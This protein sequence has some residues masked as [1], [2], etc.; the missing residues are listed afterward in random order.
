MINVK[1]RKVAVY[2]R[3]STE[4][5]E[6]LSALQNQMD[7]YKNIIS[8]HPEWIVVKEYVDEGITGTSARK[9]PAFM[10]MIKDASQKKFDL[11][12]TREVCRFARNTVDAL[13]YVRNLQRMGVE[14]FFVNDNIMT[15]DGDGEL[16]LTIMATLAQE[17]SRKT[18]ER[19]KA[20]LEISQKKGVLR[21][22][23]ILGYDKKDGVYTINEKEAEAVKLMFDLYLQGYGFKAIANILEERNY[24][25]AF[26][27]TKWHPST[28]RLTL[29]NP[30]YIGFQVQNRT[31]SDGYLTQKRVKIDDEDNVYVKGSHPLFIS[32][33]TFYECK[34]QCEE[35][36]VYLDDN[37]I[38]GKQIHQ[39]IYLKK[40]KCEC[41]S[42][43]RRIKWGYSKKKGYT[44]G[45]SC[46]TRVNYGDKNKRK[47]NNL[48]T[49]GCCANTSF[50]EWKVQLAVHQSIKFFFNEPLDN[51]TQNIIEYV[52][53]YYVDEPRKNENNPIETQEEIEQKIN[54][55]KNR[56]LNYTEMRADG[57]ITKAEYLQFKQTCQQKI[58]EL[59]EK[60]KFIRQ[61]AQKIDKKEE[62]LDNILCKMTKIKSIFLNESTIS[63][64]VDLLP[65]LFIDTVIEKVISHPNC[66]FDVYI[67]L[68]DN[69]INTQIDGNIYHA[70]SQVCYY[71]TNGNS[72]RRSYEP[73]IGIKL[74]SKEIT[75][76]DAYK[77]NCQLGRSVK[78]S[79]YDTIKVNLYISLH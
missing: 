74:F 16:R 43:F 52:N 42:S 12:I 38:V 47:E 57:E 50:P 29:L 76:Q 49:D 17:E 37:S 70:D 13:T 27:K 23:K 22:S 2:G 19:V 62:V 73:E 32:Q 55:Q 61:N 40:L 4:H 71:P 30:F 10:E 46:Y 58:D 35:R 34:K 9:R 8:S 79:S 41:G 5:F 78:L 54:K 7:W 60:L 26:G 69:P 14:V 77:F 53:K 6:Q 24:K 25:T 11:I 64:N 1:Q 63:L 33:E 59:Q 18:S 20:G 67:A 45:Y 21:G 36:R 68:N 75:K 72:N 51:L 39:T 65:D 28:V 56:I 44:Y 15:M 48:E 66:N 3:V 31:K